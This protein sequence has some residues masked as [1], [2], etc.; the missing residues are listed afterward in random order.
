MW[1]D[2]FCSRRRRRRAP[3]SLLLKPRNVRRPTSRVARTSTTNCLGSRHEVN[4]CV[5]RSIRFSLC[6]ADLLFFSI[7]GFFELDSFTQFIYSNTRAY[8]LRIRRAELI[9]FVVVPTTSRSTRRSSIVSIYT[10]FALQAMSIVALYTLLKHATTIR[11]SP[12]KIERGDRSQ[13]GI[14][15]D[16][17]RRWCQQPRPLK[18]CW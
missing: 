15:F 8:V 5:Y 17:H 1:Y 12:R 2:S 16:Q 7:R 9:R 13:A 18:L 4:S 10:G 3:R 11:R 14:L 6:I